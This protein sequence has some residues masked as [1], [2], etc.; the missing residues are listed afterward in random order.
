MV[1]VG[2]PVEWMED[3]QEEE[4]I[5]KELIN[6]YGNNEVKYWGRIPSGKVF[7]EII[8]TWMSAVWNVFRIVSCLK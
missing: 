7:L 6:I 3:I 8:R 1:I 2:L 4:V 5:K